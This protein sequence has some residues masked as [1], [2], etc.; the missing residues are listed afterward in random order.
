MTPK[1][2][3]HQYDGWISVILAVIIAYWAFKKFG[4]AGALV[5]FPVA[6]FGV[7]YVG[8]KTGVLQLDIEI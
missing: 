7:L 2:N 4:I 6:L 1:P 5:G 8:S 3:P